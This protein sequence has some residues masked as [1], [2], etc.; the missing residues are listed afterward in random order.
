MNVLCSFIKRALD[1]RCEGD[2]CTPNMHIA[3]SRGYDTDEAF[4]VREKTNIDQNM[5][6][7]KSH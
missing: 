4:Y 3:L 7:S 5:M 1:S 2:R 6:E